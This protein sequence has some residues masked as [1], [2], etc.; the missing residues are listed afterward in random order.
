MKS[1]SSRGIAL[2]LGGLLSAA[3]LSARAEVG[4]PEKEDLRFGF[5]KLTDMAPLAVAYELGYFEDEGLSVW[6]AMKPHIPMQDGKPVH[7]IKADALK[8]VVQEYRDAGHPWRR[9]RSTATAS[10]SPGTSRLC[11]R[12]YCVPRSGWMNTARKQWPCSRDHS[13]SAPTAR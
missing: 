13:M 7:P 12:P 8:P 1:S 6:Q 3:V 9:A 2:F 10:A 5:I 4:P 11:S